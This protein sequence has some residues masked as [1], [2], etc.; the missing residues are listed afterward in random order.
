MDKMPSAEANA[1]KGERP[2]ERLIAAAGDLFW[3]LGIR[4]VGVEAVAEAANTNKMTLYRHFASKDDLV[5]EWLLRLTNEDFAGWARLEEAHPED[6]A[7]QLL[8]W[9]DFV[10][11][12]LATSGERG[13]PY[14]NS[15][16]E[17]PDPAH[18]ARQVIK[19]HKTRQ[20]QR[21]ADLL[22]RIDP[23]GADALADELFFLVEGARASAHGIGMDDVPEQ[24]GRIARA[25]VGRAIAG[26]RCK[27]AL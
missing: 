21:F 19:A 26:S 5:A 22:G 27:A 12:W 1:K 7:A 11:H 15:L 18:P 13:C 24:F 4:G 3:R 20:R 23:S 9:I 25:L 6:P 8:A 16:A 2:R 17:L 14:A 10:E